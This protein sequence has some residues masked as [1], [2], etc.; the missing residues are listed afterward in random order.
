MTITPIDAQAVPAGRS[1]RLFKIAVSLGLLSSAL[2]VAA[3][4]GSLGVAGFA[5]FGPN[6]I[7][8]VTAAILVGFLLAILRLRMIS[9]D[10]GYRLTF[11]QSVAAFSMGQ[12]GGILFFQIVGQLVARGAYLSRVETNVPMAGTILI[13][14]S[15]R[16]AAALVST[17]L[18]IVGALYL[19]RGITL[20]T[21]LSPVRMLVG[22]LLV[23]A[24]CG[25]M[26]RAPIGE[27]VSGIT[28]SG[29]KRTIRAL[30]MS[31]LIQLPMMAAYVMA[32]EVTS[33]NIDLFQIAAATSLV[34]FAASIPI[35]FAG[36]GIR[37]MSA[38]AALSAVGMSTESALAVAILIGVVSI[39][40]V[41]VFA[42]LTVGVDAIK[43]PTHKSA[44]AAATSNNDFEKHETIL[45]KALPVLAAALIFFQVKLPTQ[46]NLINVNL[47]D[48]VVVI[49]GLLMLFLAILGRGPRWR[50]SGIYLHLAACI[51]AMSVALFIGAYSVGWTTWAI[52]K[53]I[54]RMARSPCDVRDRSARA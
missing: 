2:G 54:C 29:L 26:W 27:F 14:G 38:M 19:F 45:A 42:A 32:A 25:Y 4:N 9:A 41:F 7:G 35:S 8:S 23:G 6:L 53:Q 50:I 40:I 36:W 3:Y 20:D 34:M 31:F 13:T 39:V 47:A 24:A 46:S 30:L 16:L 51:I 52:T 17:I 11:M 21:S 44:G 15:E 48:P 28:A 10:L 5:K 22:L 37:E 43:A 18:A 12:V 49:G 33:P 1:S